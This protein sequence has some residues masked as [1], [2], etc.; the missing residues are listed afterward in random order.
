MIPLAIIAFTLAGLGLLGLNLSYYRA[1][2]RARR[3]ADDAWTVAQSWEETAQLL[4]SE[5]ENSER[6]TAIASEPMFLPE[7]DWA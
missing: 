2:A 5:R 4:L 7:L 3:E 1:L 6:G